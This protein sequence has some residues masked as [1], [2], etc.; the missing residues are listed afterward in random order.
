MK[1]ANPNL[2]P[3]EIM[4]ILSNTA[5]KIGGKTQKD[6]AYGNGLVD[7]VAAVEAAI[8]ARGN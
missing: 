6:N 4:D 8:A 2:T 7:T 3:T 1:Q 5:K